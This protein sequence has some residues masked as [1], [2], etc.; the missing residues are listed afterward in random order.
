MLDDENFNDRP[1]AVGPATRIPD[2]CER[3]PG[4][5]AVVKAARVGCTG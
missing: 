2:L 4:S 1:A 5:F 3:K